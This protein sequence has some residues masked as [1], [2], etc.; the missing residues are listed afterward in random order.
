MLMWVSLEKWNQRSN[1]FLQR[2]KVQIWTFRWGVS[3][4]RWFAKRNRAWHPKES[5]SLNTEW[6]MVVNALSHGLLKISQVG[7]RVPLGVG[8]GFSVDSGSFHLFRNASLRYLQKLLPCANNID[9]GWFRKLAAK[10]VSKHAWSV[11]ESTVG[12]QS[13]FFSKFGDHCDS[14]RIHCW[15][16]H[17]ALPYRK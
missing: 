9:Q 2:K 13:R 7:H 10:K 3:V 16:E 15:V 8:R 1:T 5:C 6:I 11:L 12:C 4:E 17:M 14:I